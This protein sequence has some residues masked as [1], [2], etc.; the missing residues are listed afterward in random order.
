MKISIG[1]ENLKKVPDIIAL[2]DGR[3]LNTVLR[4]RLPLCYKYGTRGHIK[5]NCPKIMAAESGGEAEG[6]QDVKLAPI[7]EPVAE[8]SMEASNEIQKNAVEVAEVQTKVSSKD[9]IRRRDWNSIAKSEMQEAEE[10]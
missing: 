7:K 5:E 3:K 9:S 10:A 2:E 8:T 4:G 6:K 1:I